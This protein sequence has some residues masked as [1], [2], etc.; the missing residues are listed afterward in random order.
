MGHT[1]HTVARG[2][3]DPNYG[4]SS[5]LGCSQLNHSSTHKCSPT[6]KNFRADEP[7]LVLDLYRYTAPTF[8][9][10]SGNNRFSLMATSLPNGTVAS[11]SNLATRPRDAAAALLRKVAAQKKLKQQSAAQ[12]QATS[13]SGKVVLYAA[14]GLA[15]AA[16]GYAIY[17]FWGAQEEQTEAEGLAR[18]ALTQ[19]HAHLTAADM[20]RV[21]ALLQRPSLSEAERR[22][23]LRCVCSFERWMVPAV[24]RQSDGNEL[25]YSFRGND[26]STGFVLFSTAAKLHSI[27][28]HNEPPVGHRQVAIALKGC[29]VC[30]TRNLSFAAVSFL[31]LDPDAEAAPPRRAVDAVLWR[32]KLA[33]FD[34]SNT[35]L[36]D[37]ADAVRMESQLGNALAPVLG[38]DPLAARTF[39]GYEKLWCLAPSGHSAALD[40]PLGLPIVGGDGAYLLLFTSIDL[41]EHAMPALRKLLGVAMVM[42]GVVDPACG[43]VRPSF[44]SGVSSVHGSGG[45]AD[46]AGHHPHRP[47]YEPRRVSMDDVYTCLRAPGQTL[48]G[49]HLNRLVPGL[50]PNYS[51]EALETSALPS[52]FQRAG[53]VPSAVA[54]G[55]SM[56]QQIA[57]LED[58]AAG[59]CTGN[60]ALPQTIVALTYMAAHVGCDVEYTAEAGTLV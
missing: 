35:A 59:A 17:R 26:G 56:A 8:T 48:H 32:P 43:P 1:G 60:K 42:S 34:A 10:L 13:S 55:P 4:P 9:D 45:S 16:A 24:R 23:L 31:S 12:P 54:R 58:S 37:L 50:S 6:A 38:A 46:G 49:L 7:K 39:A 28:Q 25:V 5:K 19:G 3:A 15:A 52:I 30:S 33:V 53:V 47:L 44:R 40:S 14:A 36:A 29:D 27:Q 21:V 11:T 20:A 22:H 41:L 18:K 57:R 51:V 2:W